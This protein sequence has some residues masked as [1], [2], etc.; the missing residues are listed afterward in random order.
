MILE[1]SNN[2]LCKLDKILKK[3]CFDH[4]LGFLV[5]M[6]ITQ[7]YVAFQYQFNS[8]IKVSFFLTL[9]YTVDRNTQKHSGVLKELN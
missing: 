6:S 7:V 4:N 9:L 8:Q 1:V 3:N 2:H 5:F